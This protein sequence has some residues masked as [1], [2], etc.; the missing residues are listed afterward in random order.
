MHS[1]FVFILFYCEAGSPVAQAGFELS[2]QPRMTF[3][4]DPPVSTS[5]VLR[6]QVYTTMPSLFLPLSKEMHLGV[7]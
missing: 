6:L 1:F 7:F 5:R 3:S 4:S 2:V